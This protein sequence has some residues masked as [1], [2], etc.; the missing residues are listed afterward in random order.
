MKCV[1]GVVSVF[2]FL[3]V[4]VLADEITAPP[5]GSAFTSS[6]VTFVW[7]AAAGESALYLGTTGPGSRDLLNT[8]LLDPA[9]SEYTAA[10]LPTNQIVYA[11]L[12]CEVPDNPGSFRIEDA[13]YNVDADADGIYDAIDPNPGSADPQISFTGTNYVFTVHGSGRI[14][15]LVSP[16]I[17]EST[18][19]SVDNAPMRALTSLVYQ[20][21]EDVFDFV[22]FTNNQ[23]D[24][25]SYAGRFYPAKNE[26]QGI[27][28]SPFDSTAAFGSAGALQGAIHIPVPRALPSGPSLHEICHNWGNYLSSIPTV[29]SGH[30]GTSSVG[31]QLG[32]FKAGSLVDLGN[33]T[34]QVSNPRTGQPG[35]FGTFANGG[36]GLPYSEFELYLMGMIPPSEVEFPIQIIN[37]LDWVDSSQG[38][39]TATSITTRTMADIIQTDGARIPV[40]ADAQKEFRI[41]YVVISADPLDNP[42]WGELDQTVYD[43]ALPGDNGI[44]SYNFWE[45][46]GG[47]G[48][49]K[50]DGLLTTLRADIPEIRISASISTNGSTAADIFLPSVP[51][52]LYE[53]QRAGR[54]DGTWTNAASLTG[55]GSALTFSLIEP[56]TVP[57]MFY[58]VAHNPLQLRLGSA[59]GKDMATSCGCV[60]C[61]HKRPEFSMPRQVFTFP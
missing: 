48:T 20:H 56:P 17:F 28:R 42:T 13:V 22:M 16:A 29:R 6:T 52:V 46:T 24:S 59:D 47:R 31:G 10:S 33:G 2:C 27:G 38:I 1:F 61:D 30:W 5:N 57:R 45:A 44:S 40:A 23:D 41:L 58:R 19:N 12:F 4:L 9:I 14:S 36:N 25:D 11:R 3:S 51:G 37:Q 15:S 53:L 49:V 7:P 32:G 54:P 55:T 50:M 39:L 35:S 21:V 18:R 60:G 8:G 43:F 34:Y 26:T